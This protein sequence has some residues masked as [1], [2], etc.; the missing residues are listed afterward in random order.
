VLVSLTINFF[1]MA[2]LSLVVA[3][4]SWRRFVEAHLPAVLT[5]AL[6]GGLAFLSVTALRHSGAGPA[7]RLLG[8]LLVTC[9]G[10]A[11]LLRRA[12][13]SLLGPYGL[14]MLTLLGT[15]VPRRGAPLR[16]QG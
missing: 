11:L 3:H 10:T 16:S 14:K 2:Q 8:A 12:P 13:Q 7:L 5:S 4:S 15:F 6:A 1:L 9:L